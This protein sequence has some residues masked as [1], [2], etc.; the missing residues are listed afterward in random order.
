VKSA[1]G[2]EDGHIV[3][4]ENGLEGEPV[5]GSIVVCDNDLEYG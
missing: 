3:E 2:A 1:V 5:L 4:E